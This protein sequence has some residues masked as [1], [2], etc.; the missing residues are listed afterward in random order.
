MRPAPPRS[1]RYPT[2][3]LRPDA[4][5]QLLGVGIKQVY[6]LAAIEEW[7]VTKDGLKRTQYAVED[8]RASKR[9]RDEREGRDTTTKGPAS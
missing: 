3:W 7:R 9:R 5:A 4:A 2:G 1:G 8:V 6:R